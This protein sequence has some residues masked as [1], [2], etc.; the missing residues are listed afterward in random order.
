MKFYTQEVRKIPFVLHWLLHAKHTSN[1][2]TVKFAFPA[3]TVGEFASKKT[4][5]KEI[6]QEIVEVTNFCSFICR[7][8]C[9]R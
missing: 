5:L 7:P 3:V 4:G 1:R 8:F 2:L 6:C 9:G